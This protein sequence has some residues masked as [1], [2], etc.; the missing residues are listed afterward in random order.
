MTTKTD[1]KNAPIKQLVLNRQ[2]VKNLGVRSAVRTGDRPV[3][4]VTHGGTC[5]SGNV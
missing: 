3:G 5:P 4:G 1:S 2:T